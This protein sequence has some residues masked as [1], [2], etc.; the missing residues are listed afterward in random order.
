MRSRP[1]EHFHRL[2]GIW[3]RNL[4]ESGDESGDRRDVPH[5]LELRNWGQS[6][7]SPVYSGLFLIGEWPGFQT[8]EATT[9]G[10][11]PSFA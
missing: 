8:A 9:D 5:F 1:L 4:E 10:G 6:R 7:L 3:D 2:T 11:A